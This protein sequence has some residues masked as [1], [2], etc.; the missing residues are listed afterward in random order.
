[1]F[2]SLKPTQKSH[3]A[4]EGEPNAADAD[5]ASMEGGE[6]TSVVDTVQETNAGAGV[7]AAEASTSR[8]A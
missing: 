5:G 6:T 3:S 7:E 2:N 4:K 1:M 8:S